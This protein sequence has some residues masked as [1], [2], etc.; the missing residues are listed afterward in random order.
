MVY[1]SV[2]DFSLMMAVV[3]IQNM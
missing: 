2:F 3:K 1:T